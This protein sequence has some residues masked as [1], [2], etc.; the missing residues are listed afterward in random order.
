MVQTATGVRLIDNSGAYIA[1]IIK[2]WG[3]N[4]KTLAYLGNLAVVTL[5]KIKRKQKKVKKGQVF[6]FR[7]LR[8]KEKT[9]RKDGS[10]IKFHNAGGIL[11]NSQLLPFGSR[12][13]GPLPRE[14]KRKY[15]RIC[16]LAKKLM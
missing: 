16:S 8:R 12:I 7:L 5:K 11:L 1:K 2:L 15:S 9:T 6:K 4:K 10:Y 14:L 3:G 13:V